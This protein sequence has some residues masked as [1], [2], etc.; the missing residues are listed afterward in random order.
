MPIDITKIKAAKKQE[1]TQAQSVATDP[2]KKEETAKKEVAQELQN[3]LRGNKANQETAKADLIKKYE[4]EIG[5][6][7]KKAKKYA[8]LELQNLIAKEKVE[9]TKVF[10]DKEAY[11][12]A[13]AE[14]KDNKYANVTYIKN[15]KVRELVQSEPERFNGENGF[16]AD[17]Y[18]ERV[19]S[20]TGTDYKQN[21]DER[22]VT[23]KKNGISKRAAKKMAKYGGFETEKDLTWLKRAGIV[24]GGAALGAPLGA[25]VGYAVMGSTTVTAILNQMISVAYPDKTDIFKNSKIEEFEH[26]NKKDGALVGSYA[27]AAGGAVGGAFGAAFTK[28][29]GG[30]DIFNGIN[31]RAFVEEGARGVR[32]KDNEQI[33]SKGIEVLKGK[34]YNTD[35]IVKCIQV[36][37]A[38]RTNGKANERELIAFYE[39][40]KQMPVKP[41][42]KK[43]DCDCDEVK[44]QEPVKKDEFPHEGTE[45]NLEKKDASFNSEIKVRKE[46]ETSE[47]KEQVPRYNFKKGEYPVGVIMAKYGMDYKTAMKYNQQHRE[48]YNLGKNEY[49][50]FIDTPAAITIDGKTYNYNP[51]AKAPTSDETNP[52]L[53]PVDGARTT[54]KQVTKEKAVGE[55]YLN[56]K[57]I[58]TV[59]AKTEAEAKQKAK[60]L[61]EQE[62]QKLQQAK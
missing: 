42:E 29:N 18:K 34:G 39:A 28:D 59:E 6:K 13:K 19:Q 31:I 23:A 1:T 24:T 49:T 62:K 14:A 8:N 48:K 50:N 45:I 25:G 44:K 21:L 17:K 27:G 5:L 12:E 57:L 20:F 30:K 16:S 46:T 15:K 35:D 41:E 38:E 60:Q 10:M 58:G 33:L 4:E 3:K 2:V 32:G 61:I 51:D 40:A 9:D 7:H 53:V 54:T 55:A 47:V 22:H 52:K 37:V 26:S 56:G 11:K 36:G 43:K